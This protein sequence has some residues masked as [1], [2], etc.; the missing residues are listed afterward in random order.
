MSQKAVDPVG[1]VLS[2]SQLEAALGIYYN[3]LSARIKFVWVGEFQMEL[4]FFWDSARNLS[5][6][7]FEAKH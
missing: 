5:Q 4:L 6:S 3:A 7:S 1:A 2:L